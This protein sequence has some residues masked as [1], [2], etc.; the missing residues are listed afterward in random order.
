MLGT[1]I[2]ASTMT[3]ALIPDMI[4]AHANLLAVV[5]G[6][7]FRARHAKKAISN[8][9]N[10]TMKKGLIDWYNSVF[11]SLASPLG[12]HLSFGTLLK[13]GS[14]PIV[15]SAR[16]ESPVTG[17]RYESTWSTSCGVVFT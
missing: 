14:G 1:D 3:N 9:V 15:L 10:A 17:R 6:L 2:T 5:T 4:I 8:G 7:F 13:Y 12:G 16:P 11:A